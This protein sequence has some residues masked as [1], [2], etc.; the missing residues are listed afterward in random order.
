MN[1]AYNVIIES[2]KER[3]SLYRGAAIKNSGNGIKCRFSVR[4][5]LGTMRVKRIFARHWQLLGFCRF[6]TA[7]FFETL[8]AGLVL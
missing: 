8:G 3:M 6:F 2:D 1:F 5:K 4:N 7:L